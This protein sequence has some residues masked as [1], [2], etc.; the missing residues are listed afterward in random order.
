MFQCHKQTWHY[1]LN[2][3]TVVS[4]NSM[5]HVI[6]NTRKLSSV[7]QTPQLT[8]KTTHYLVLVFE[9]KSQEEHFCQCW[10][11]TEFLPINTPISLS[12]RVVGQLA[13]W[14]PITNI[15]LNAISTS[16]NACSHDAEYSGMYYLS[17]SSFIQC[18]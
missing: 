2:K 1:V 6:V 5:I 7:W 9:E 11:M 18:F 12:G 15:P 14:Q 13:R 8:N 3:K 16:Y 10:P 17:I 4:L